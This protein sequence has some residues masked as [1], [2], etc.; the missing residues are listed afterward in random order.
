MDG[1]VM[2]IILVSGIAVIALL[3]SLNC[4]RKP[5]VKDKYDP[6]DDVDA[7]RSEVRRLRNELVCVKVN[8]NQLKW[9]QS[10]AELEPAI[11][12]YA[13]LKGYGDYE[14]SLDLVV[15]REYYSPTHY[16]GKE[17][18]VELSKMQGKLDELK[19]L[20]AKLCCKK[21]SKK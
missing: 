19:E 15:F 1:I 21:G 13:E 17:E 6:R 11:K 18:Y 10:Y 5:K 20:K 9:H 12:E 14:N 8:L 4:A 16:V 2:G 3:T 7:L